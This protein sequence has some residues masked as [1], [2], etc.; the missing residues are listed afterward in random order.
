MLRASA[1]LD[2]LRRDMPTSEMLD[3]A[4]KMMHQGQCNCA[5]WHGVFGGL[6]LNHLRTALYEKIIASDALM[7][8]VEVR[9]TAESRFVAV[10]FDADGNLEGILE[11]DRIALFFK[12]SDGGT[13]FEFDYKPQPFNFGNVLTRREEVYHDHLRCDG[14]LVGEESG[15]DLSIHELVKAK[16]KDLDKLLV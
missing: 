10:D 13:L 5:Y 3:E 7:D 12:P 4:E 11:N 9:D 6:Y 1:R 15:G 8:T 14:V 16:E 2:R